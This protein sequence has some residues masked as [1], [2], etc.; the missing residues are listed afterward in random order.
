[1]GKSAL[2]AAWL[3]RRETAGDMVPHHFIRR[4]EIRGLP[5]VHPRQLDVE[6]RCIA[7]V[8]TTLDHVQQTVRVKRVAPREREMLTRRNGVGVRRIRIER[9]RRARR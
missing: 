5:C 8:T 1:M 6:V 2:L 7:R 3:A 4:G 9:D